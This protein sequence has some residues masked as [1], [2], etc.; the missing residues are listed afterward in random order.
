M[1]ERLTQHSPTTSRTN[2]R[3]RTASPG[4]EASA[5]RLSSAARALRG[6]IL[7]GLAALLVAILAACQTSSQPSA[8]ATING[9]SVPR[10][11]YDALV[12]ASQRRAEQV[13]L[14]V[15]WDTSEGTQRLSRIQS[16]TIKQLVRDA[17]I[18]EV[19][20]ERNVA[21]SDADLD[22][23]MARIEGVFGG[24]AGVDQ[25]LNQDGLSRADF[26]ELYRYFLLDQKL[27]QADPSGYPS[28]LDQALK[29][30]DVQ[31]FVGPCADNHD[32]RTCI[33]TK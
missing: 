26:R 15:R 18:A 2:P 4:I 3:L 29:S 23:G 20:R 31:V 10:H 30:A 5:G 14:N 33:P 28:A 7:L 1:F 13:G 16:D 27:R 17:V 21:V 9:V 24:A 6:I 32:F 19:G 11:L 22:A 25:K 12:T 8:A